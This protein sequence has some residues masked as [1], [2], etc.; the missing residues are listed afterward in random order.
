MSENR[1]LP[2]NLQFFAEQGEDDQTSEQS[3]GNE[4]QSGTGSQ[5][6]SEEKTFTQEDVNNIAA[7]EAKKAQEKLLKQL[8]IEDFDNAKE[9]FQKFQEW[10]E[11][12]KTE[13]EK[14]A[15]QLEQL[16]SD[17]KQKDETISGLQA[18]LSA[19]KT[20]VIADSVE[21]VVALAKNYVSDDV[22]M[23]TAIKQVIEKYPHFAKAEQEQEEK[24]NF[25]TG[26][27]QSNGNKNND[28]FM[29]KLAKYK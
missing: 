9:G 12:Q 20:G 28:P 23:D 18:Q 16:T 1:F 11:S 2:L 13:A 14:Q 7:R 8:G 5:Q 26:Q 24:P 27:H 25:T 15:E 17:N 29:A 6:Q 4:E 19:L 21:D 10:Q 3:G 22:D